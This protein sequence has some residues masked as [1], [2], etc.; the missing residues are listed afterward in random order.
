MKVEKLIEQLKEA[1]S[2]NKEYAP[3]LGALI[4][5]IISGDVATKKRIWNSLVGAGLGYLVSGLMSKSKNGEEEENE[6]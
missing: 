1:I 2:K 6:E 5:Y 4:G 3:L